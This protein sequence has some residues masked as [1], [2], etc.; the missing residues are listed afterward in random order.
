[1]SSIS[2]ETQYRD[3]VVLASFPPSVGQSFTLPNEYGAWKDLTRHLAL[4][5]PGILVSAGAERSFF[6]VALSAREVCQGLIVRD[7]HPHIKAY[8][9]FNTAL[10][11][12][13]K[14][15]QDYLQLVDDIYCDPEQLRERIRADLAIP[16]AMREYYSANLDYFAEVFFEWP[17][18][19]EDH[20]MNWRKSELFYAVAYH[21]NDEQFSKIQKL[22]R[23]G[24]IIATLGDINDLRCFDG[25]R[26]TL[27]DTSNIHDSCQ[28]HLQT[29]HLPRVM[30]TK[31]ILHQRTQF[32]SYRTE[33]NSFQLELPLTEEEMNELEIAV[34][35]TWLRHYGNSVSIEKG[36]LKPRDVKNAIGVKERANVLSPDSP[37]HAPPPGSFSRHNL[38]KLKTLP[39]QTHY[40]VKGNTVLKERARVSAPSSHHLSQSEAAEAP[41]APRLGCC[42]RFIRIIQNILPKIPK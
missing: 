2:L 14:D 41:P 24:N 15:R 20:Q 29:A 17:R 33:Y 1:M 13:A 6:D 16:V 11:R 8:V 7:I 10:F 42:G 35:Q 27:V 23:A 36:P 40:E 30:W 28:I 31:L 34:R 39:A 5:E 21:K 3:Q 12:I 26:I 32:S 38:M 22:A 4:Q 9:D 18:L 19:L 25:S 37:R